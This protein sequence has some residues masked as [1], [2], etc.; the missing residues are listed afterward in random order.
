MQSNEKIRRDGL[1][2]AV[3]KLLVQHKQKEISE[4][5]LKRCIA[6]SKKLSE[7]DR[8]EL[9][10]KLL[11][12]RNNR[13]EKLKKAI[14]SNKNKAYIKSLTDMYNSSLF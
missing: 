11:N 10:E 12:E 5:T 9:H 13:E 1:L 8:K 2:K 7:E 6:A 14:E 4:S 3:N